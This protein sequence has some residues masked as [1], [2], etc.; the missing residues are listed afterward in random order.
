MVAGACLTRHLQSTPPAC[1][2]PTS[3]F[4]TTSPS[5][6]AAAVSALPCIVCLL[7]LLLVHVRPI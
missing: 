2:S 4:C 1:C 7:V 6:V 3:A 5:A